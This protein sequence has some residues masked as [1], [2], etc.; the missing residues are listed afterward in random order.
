MSKTEFYTDCNT[1][2]GFT[3]VNDFTNRNFA[4]DKLILTFSSAIFSRINNIATSCLK[5]YS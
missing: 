1:A 5:K 2:N 4:K 3:D